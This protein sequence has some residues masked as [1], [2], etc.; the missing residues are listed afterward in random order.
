MKITCKVIE[1]MLP[2]YEEQML[3]DDSIQLVEEHLKSCASCRDTLKELQEEPLQKIYRKKEDSEKE[4]IEAFLKIRRN[5]WK[6]RILS[7]VIAAGCVLGCARAGYYFYAEKETYIPYEKTGLYM[8]D[9]K[10]CADQT[11]QGRLQSI[12]SP[13]QKIQFLYETETA[14]VRKR[15]PIK[16][17]KQEI[18]DYANQPDPE[19]FEYPEDDI[20]GPVGIE[21]LYYL[22]AEYA[23]ERNKLLKTLDYDDPDNEE[24]TKLIEEMEKN[25]VLMWEKQ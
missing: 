17:G 15:N 9:G 2:L 6:K 4:A 13:D 8:E 7:A 14:E 16:K 24:S 21:K 23:K 11:Y 25:S 20:A 3:S 10:L 22:S 18:D 1:D 19:T 5:I 12:I